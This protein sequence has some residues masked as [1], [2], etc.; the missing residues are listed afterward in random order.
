MIDQSYLLVFFLDGSS[1][2][3]SSEPLIEPKVEILADDLMNKSR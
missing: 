1:T 2:L 3:P